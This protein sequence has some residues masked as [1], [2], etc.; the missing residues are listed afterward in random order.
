MTLSGGILDMDKIISML[1]DLRKIRVS[2]AIDDFGT[3]YSSLSYIRHFPIQRLKI[4]QSF[5]RSMVDDPPT[6]A[7]T[8]T[9]INLGHSLNLKVIAEGVETQEQLDCLRD[10]ECD[11]VQGYY[12][13][14]PLTPEDFVKLAGKK[15]S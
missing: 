15:A 8:K 10:F 13:A 14:R 4:D 2:L 7:I 9:I 3:S 1:W 11:E 12:L 6:E 5:I